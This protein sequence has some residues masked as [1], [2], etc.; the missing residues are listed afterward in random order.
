[1]LMRQPTAQVSEPEYGPHDDPRMPMELTLAIGF[2]ITLTA[3]A[4][5]TTVRAHTPLAVALGIMAATVLILAWWSRIGGAALSAGLGWLMLNGFV[6]NQEGL[7]AWHGARDVI[8][9]SV[10]LAVAVLTAA[11]RSVQLA[12]HGHTSPHRY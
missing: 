12:H 4:G 2:V 11:I 5:L 3:A 1:M 9:L 7:L 10:L 6:I 8:S